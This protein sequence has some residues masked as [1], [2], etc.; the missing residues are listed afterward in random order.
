MG[1]CDRWHRVTLKGW[2]RDPNT[3]RAQYLLKLETSNLVR[4]L[5]WGMP[6]GRTNN[7]PRK[8]VW[9]RYHDPFNF[10][11]TIEHISKNYLSQR[12]RIWYVALYGE[13]RAGTQI[14]FIKSGRGLRH[15]AL[16]FQLIWYAYQCAGLRP[17]NNTIVVIGRLFMSVGKR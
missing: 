10:W 16:Q 14:I 4:R 9:P 8:L 5:V 12:L 15:E 2:T 11:H 3:I 1:S 13:C 6:S 7:F 17:D